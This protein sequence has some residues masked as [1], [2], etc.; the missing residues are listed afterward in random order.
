MSKQIEVQ[1]HGSWYLVEI[2]DIRA[3]PIQVIVDGELVE[4]EVESLDSTTV[5]QTHQ[6]TPVTNVKTNL[7]NMVQA[8]MPGIVVSVTVSIGQQV[9]QGDQL[10]LLEAIKLEQSIRSPKA[11]IVK[12]IHIDPGQNVATGQAMLEL[13]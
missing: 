13:E 8:P 7:G 5:T 1:L 11:G 3:N 10:C 2:E 4:V 12:A 6:L 9:S